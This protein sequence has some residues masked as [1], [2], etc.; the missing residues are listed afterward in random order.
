ML[1]STNGPEMERVARVEPYTRGAR[2]GGE[3]KAKE[4]K[5]KRN[6]DGSMEGGTYPGELPGA[7]ADKCM[8]GIMPVS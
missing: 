5:K 4:E 6:V 3:Q 1:G 2:L 8:L 7:N